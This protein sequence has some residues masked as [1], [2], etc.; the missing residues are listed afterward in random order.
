MPGKLVERQHRS[1]QV[2]AIKFVEQSAVSM[3]FT[4]QKAD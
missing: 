4:P 1:P 3:Q 2:D